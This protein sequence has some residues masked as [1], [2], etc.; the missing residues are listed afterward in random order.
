MTLVEMYKTT[1]KP[2]LKFYFANKKPNLAVNTKLK[3]F[4]VCIST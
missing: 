1:P 3:L 4:L 2:K